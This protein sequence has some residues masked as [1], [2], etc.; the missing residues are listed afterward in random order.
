MWHRVRDP[1]SSVPAKAG[2]LRVFRPG[3]W[4]V[5][6]RAH[7]AP[8][9]QRGWGPVLAG[10]DR[11]LRAPL[12]E[13]LG[14]S[15]G[16]SPLRCWDVVPLDPQLCF[17][18]SGGPPVSPGPHQHT[19]LHSHRLQDGSMGLFGTHLSL[20]SDDGPPWPSVQCLE[21]CCFKKIKI[22]TLFHKLCLFFFPGRRVNLV[23]SFY[24]DR[25]LFLIKKKGRK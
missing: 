24:L 15:P 6:T 9:E 7:S 11:H 13:P 20:L 5:G 17:S 16:L 22:K 3:L 4:L 8:A 1:L 25:A 10:S 18:N 23:P 2:P 21:N 14:F 19:P 12:C